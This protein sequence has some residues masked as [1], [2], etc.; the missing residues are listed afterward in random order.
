MKIKVNSL[1]SE[2]RIIKQGK[3][4]FNKTFKSFQEL[5]SAMFGGKK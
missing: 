2:K 5:H 4:R 3:Y 1:P